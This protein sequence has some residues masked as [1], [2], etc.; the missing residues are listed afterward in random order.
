MGT[1][2]WVLLNSNRAVKEIIAKQAAVTGERPDFPVSGG[3][4]SRNNR[5]VLRK[6]AQWQE[7]RKMMH[8]LLSGTALRTYGHIQEEESTRL[9][10]SYL[11]TPDQW[12]RH[13]Y[14]YAYSII[15]RIVLGERPKQTK[16]ELDEFRRITVEFILSISSSIFDFWPNFGIL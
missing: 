2:T 4:V 11:Y 5:T 15:H 12:Y 7:G 9:L 13:H 1:R 10:H 6:T 8:H 3:L 14:D 16:M